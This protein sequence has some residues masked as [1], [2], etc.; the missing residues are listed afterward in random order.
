MSYQE[1]G[2]NLTVT[3]KQKI[4][5]AINK[6]EAITIRLSKDQL[7]GSDKMVLTQQQIKK[8]VKHK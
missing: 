4:A 2:L 7:H 1:F 3:Q 8:I 6:K 5:R